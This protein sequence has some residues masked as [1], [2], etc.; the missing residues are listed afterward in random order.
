MTDE[1]MGK[2]SNDAESLRLLRASIDD[3]ER[4]GRAQSAPR[5]RHDIGNG[6]GAARNAL[7]LFDEDP[8]AVAAGRFIQIARRN[9]ERVAELL[10]QGA[11]AVDDAPSNDRSNR[12]ERND[13]G[14]AGEREHGDTLGL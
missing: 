3:L 13:L 8:G 4:R 14:G 7:E 10:K 11:S 12:N 6:I 5:L 2:V 9:V 1:P